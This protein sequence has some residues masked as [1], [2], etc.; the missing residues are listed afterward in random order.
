MLRFRSADRRRDDPLAAGAANA[1]IAH[2]IPAAHDRSAVR[3]RLRCRLDAETELSAFRQQ[4]SCLLR[5]RFPFHNDLLLCFDPGVIAGY[6]QKVEQV[7]C[8]ISFQADTG[9]KKNC[10]AQF[11]NTAGQILKRRGRFSIQVDIFAEEGF[12]YHTNGFIELFKSL[13]SRGKMMTIQQWDCFIANFIFP[14]ETIIFMANPIIILFQSRFEFFKFPESQIV[15]IARD[16]DIRRKQFNLAH[17]KARLTL[18]STNAVKS[19]P[20]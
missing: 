2:G 9:H 5:V 10:R 7:P 16:N 3:A 6:P 4:P 11:L 18:S 15:Q 20:T 1:H 12:C 13:S 14:N 19:F 8:Q 17:K